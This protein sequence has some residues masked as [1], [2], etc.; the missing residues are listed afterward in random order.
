[1]TTTTQG[2]TATATFEASEALERLRSENGPLVLHVPGGAEDAG[3]PVCLC[4]GELAIG[5][6]DHVL[7]VV[8]GVTIYRM[9][10]Q[11]SGL[12]PDRHHVLELIDAMPVGFSLHPAP[13]KAFRLREVLPES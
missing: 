7:A 10:S 2:R 12:E 9:P 13:G 11:P 6:R 8:D 3:S 5:P 1:M 4:A